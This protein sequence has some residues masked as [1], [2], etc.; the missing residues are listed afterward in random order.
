ME[1]C[2]EK[3]FL[4]TVLKVFMEIGRTRGCQSMCLGPERKEADQLYSGLKRAQ[5]LTDVM[6]KTGHNAIPQM[7]RQLSCVIV[8]PVANSSVKARGD[9]ESNG[10][11]EISESETVQG[12]AILVA[13][14]LGYQFGMQPQTSTH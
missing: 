2:L 8:P 12:G 6:A 14:R 11:K 10:Q 9:F 1:R 7:A 13:A 5:G 4:A 3:S